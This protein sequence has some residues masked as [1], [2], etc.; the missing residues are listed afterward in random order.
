MSGT[1]DDASNPQIKDDR[2]KSMQVATNHK[3]FEDGELNL[4]RSYTQIAFNGGL[5]DKLFGRPE[6]PRFEDRLNKP[7][8]PTSQPASKP[9][10]KKPLEKPTTKPGGR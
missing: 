6:G 4:E 10:G 7:K 9:A 5:S 2:T 3:I 8:P 1:I